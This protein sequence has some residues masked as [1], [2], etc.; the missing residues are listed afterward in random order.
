MLSF[1]HVESVNEM[2]IQV[3]EGY[4]II[5]PMRAQGGALC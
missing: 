5:G 2:L 1:H 3:A 4:G